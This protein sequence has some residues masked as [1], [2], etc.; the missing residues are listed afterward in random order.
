MSKIYKYA[1]I[2]SGLLILKNQNI[3]VSDPTTFNDPFDTELLVKS[4]DIK[5]GL[6]TYVDFMLENE[7]VDCCQKVIDSGN[8][9]QKGICQRFINRINRR[10]AK[11]RKRGSYYPLITL[12]YIKFMAKV[13]GFTIP[14][15]KRLI[16]MESFAS[17]EQM[18]GDEGAVKLESI[19][20]NIPRSL[21]VSCFSKRPDISK[22]WSHYANKHNGICLEYE[23]IKNLYPISYIT[24]EKYVKFH[25]FVGRYL[26]M[27]CSSGSQLLEKDFSVLFP[28]LN[29]SK[30]WKEEQ[31]MRMVI[32]SNDSL[33]KHETINNRTLDLYPIGKPSRVII[34]V[35]VDE[36]KKNEIVTFCEKEQIPFAICKKKNYKITVEEESI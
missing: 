14:E 33:I 35:N 36:L 12:D 28:I 10:R 17:I 18:I 29:K 6:R 2:D 21:R 34:G 1:S 24:R 27:V 7:M 8:I 5:N 23:N 9:K 25:K 22:M 26:A 11:G 3:V 19:I 4:F 30:D 13:F 32:S 15:D 31:E 20:G 16:A